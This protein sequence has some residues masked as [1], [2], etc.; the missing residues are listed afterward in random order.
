MIMA[1]TPLYKGFAFIDA[2]QGAYS[3]CPLRLECLIYPTKPP[4][5][6][7]IS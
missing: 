6:Q 7:A 3:F 1:P 2:H 4:V 5:P